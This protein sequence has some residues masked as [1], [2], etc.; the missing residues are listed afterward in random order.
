VQVEPAA[1]GFRAI[2]DHAAIGIAIAALDGR[3]VDVNPRFAQILGR[4]TG[5]LRGVSIDSIT[6]ADD[7]V[8]SRARR[9]GLIAGESSEFLLEKRYIRGDES[10]VWSRT[11]VVLMRSPEG[12]PR[13]FLAVVED[14]SDR[15]HADDALR[16]TEEFRRTIIE[17]SRDCFKTLALDG[18]VLWINEAGARAI[19]AN[20]PDLAGKSWIDFWTDEQRESARLAVDV[21]AAGGTGRFVGF[22][23]SDTHASWWEVVISPVLDRNGQPEQLLAI[24]RDVTE[25]YKVERALQ[26]ETRILETLNRTGTM[27]AAQLDLQSVLQ[28]VTDAGTDIIGAGHG[29]FVAKLN[30]DSDVFRVQ[31]LVGLDVFTRGAARPETAP[32]L[33]RT[34]LGGATIRCDDVRTDP[35]FAQWAAH[36]TPPEAAPRMVSFLATPVTSRAGELVGG[37]FFAHPDE[38]AFTVRAE[39]LITGIA[40]QAA[41]AIDNARLYE[42]S[43]RAAQERSQLLESERFARAEA[44]RASAMKDEFLATLSHELRTPLSAILGWSQVLRYRDPMEP[45]LR[46]ALETIERN[47]RAQAELINDLLDMSRITSG[48]L[49]LEVQPVEPTAIVD[50]AIDTVAAAARMKRISIHR[51]LDRNAGPVSADRGR[52]QQIVWNLVANAIKFTPEGGRIDVRLVRTGG[53]VEITVS[54]TGVGIKP[55]FLPF[56]FDRFRQ[57]DSSTTR[58]FGG[59]GIGLSIVKHLVELHGGSVEVSS[60][61]E[62]RGTRFTVCLPLLKFSGRVLTPARS[63][64]SRSS[65][66]VHYADLNGVR[67]LVVDDAEDA[68]EL[69]RRVLAECG[70]EVILAP[71]ASAAIDH[72]GAQRPHVLVSDIG[73]PDLDG[74]ELLRRVRTLGVDAG[75][76]C[77][78]IALTAYARPDDRDRA[79]QAGFQAHLT[80]PVEPWELVASVARAAGR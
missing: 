57:S 73:M 19:G 72:V 55:D 75:G 48:K 33:A 18:T 61:G 10:L 39:R 66:A 1:E 56:V 22:H 74:Y 68:R 47:A 58:S 36:G 52:L 53:H 69:A 45:D 71:T 11:I 3:L 37:L 24:S 44:E 9:H 65:K 4:S 46:Q 63:S 5:D 15:R 34:L 54:D 43:V 12:T 26:E 78:A 62:G 50:A 31:A 30:E 49:S 60:E 7:A 42:A 35:R 70:A 67:V 20:A 41:V 79:L 23:P 28:A 59:L 25:R 27:L 8:T 29:A 13:Q 80:K 32:M 2:F 40:A 16:R 38:G 64:S 17:S 51:A 21:A 77:P 6:H 76:E 14:I